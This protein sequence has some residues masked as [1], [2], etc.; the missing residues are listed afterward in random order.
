MIKIFKIFYIISLT[1]LHYC[2][3]C[4]KAYVFKTIFDICY[5]VAYRIFAPIYQSASNIL[6]NSFHC[7]LVSPECHPLYFLLCLKSRMLS[8]NP[9]YS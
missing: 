2:K 6:E 1:Y 5:Q 4:T 7:I 9:F 3:Y 8:E